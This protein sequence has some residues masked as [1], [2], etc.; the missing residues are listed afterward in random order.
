[1]HWRDREHFKRWSEMILRLSEQSPDEPI[2]HAVACLSP[3]AVD[4]TDRE[5]A[6][7]EDV[8]QRV[9]SRRSGSGGTDAP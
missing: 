2:P 8:A 4:L 5:R 9:A 1:M 7:A 3:D 6:W